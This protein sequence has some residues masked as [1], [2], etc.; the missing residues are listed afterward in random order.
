MPHPEQSKDHQHIPSE[1]NGIGN[2]VTADSLSDLPWL[3]EPIMAVLGGMALTRKFARI[4]EVL[5]GVGHDLHGFNAA[6]SESYVKTEEFSDLLEK[7]LKQAAGE[8][9]E[10]KRRIY[11]D[12]LVGAIRSPGQPY[13]EMDT[14]LRQLEV[15]QPDHLRIL[16]AMVQTPKPIMTGYGSRRQTLQ[17]RLSNPPIANLGELITDLNSWRL[18]EASGLT[19]TMTASGA[20]RVQFMVTAQGQ[21]LLH[22]IL[23]A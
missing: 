5:D 12:F 1:V 16:K 3:K 20:E 10:D 4:S 15:V 13:D 7:T 14:V 11:R 19:T 23:Q 17:A 8:R 6:A 18:T 9:N 22:Y 2:L 21:R